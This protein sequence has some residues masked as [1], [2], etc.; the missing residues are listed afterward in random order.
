MSQEVNNQSDLAKEQVN[1]DRLLEMTNRRIEQ[2]TEE[3]KERLA[4]A[5]E[6]YL[7][8]LTRGVLRDLE[9]TFPEFLTNTNRLVFAQHG[10]VFFGFFER[11]TTR[12]QL[13]QLRAQFRAYLEQT[14]I[15][16]ELDEQ[17]RKLATQRV[18][19]TREL[20]DVTRQLI[21]TRPV[22]GVRVAPHTS[23]PSHTVVFGQTRHGMSVHGQDVVL[24]DGDDDDGFANG[25][26]LAAIVDSQPDQVVV[27]QDGPVVLD[28][29]PVGNDGGSYGNA[30][31]GGAGM[32]D[33]VATAAAAADAGAPA[34]CVIDTSDSLGTFS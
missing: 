33:F 20:Q 22:P 6:E 4:A 5:V 32:S 7:P 16:E 24:V 1:L 15:C 29:G 34:A 19:L 25:M 2:C 18:N 26:M 14:D 28:G 3:R 17:L 31:D 11:S 10:N 30:G 13:L 9:K 23:Q 12:T 8:S 21:R 27:V